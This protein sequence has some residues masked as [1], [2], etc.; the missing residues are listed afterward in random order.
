MS[1]P[2]ATG[3]GFAIA[4]GE[5]I[6]I[7]SLLYFRPGS[8][9]RMERRQLFATVEP[10]QPTERG[11]EVASA[12]LQALKDGFAA[13][14]DQPVPAALG[15]AFAD[16]NAAVREENRHRPSDGPDRRVFVGA[17]AVV[18][19]GRELVIAQV[20]PTQAA[21]VQEGQVYAFPALAS[22][23]PQFQPSFE[24][25]GPDTEPLGRSDQ[26]TVDIFRTIAA[27][28]D[29]IVM[30]ASAI[31]IAAARDLSSISSLTESAI[32]LLQDALRPGDPDRVVDHF[33]QVIERYRLDDAHAAC[34]TIGRLHSLDP[35][36]AREYAARAGL[37]WGL[38]RPVVNPTSPARAR[39][40]RSR[41]ATRRPA[42]RSAL[43][44][45]RP[46]PDLNRAVV[47]SVRRCA[48]LAARRRQR[49][50]PSSPLLDRHREL[51]GAPLHLPWHVSVPGER[52]LTWVP[53]HRP[54][55]RKDGTTVFAGG[56]IPGAIDLRPFSP[57]LPPVPAAEIHDHTE[58]AAKAASPASTG[59]AL[60]E[61]QPGWF[62]RARIAAMSFTE[63]IAPP[64]PARGH[65][66]ARRVAP[67]ALSIERHRA[68]F[69]IGIT[70]DFRS[71]LPR[72]SI[73]PV[74]RPILFVIL[75]IL[76]AFSTFGYI[77]ARILPD[78]EAA[79]IERLLS[80][81]NDHITGAEQAT[82]RTI[83]FRELAQASEALE[84]AQIEG[85]DPDEV[86]TV[87]ARL[88][89]ARDRA[90]GI[91]RLAAGNQIG[92]LPLAAS[93]HHII[94]TGDEIYIV[95]DALY[96]FDRG[97]HRLIRTLAPG[98]RLGETIVGDFQ[99]VG[100]DGGSLL[101]TDGSV[102]YTLNAL[103]DWG[104][105]ALSPE[106]G[107]ASV[108]A[109]ASIAGYDGNLYLLDQSEGRILRFSDE[110]EQ[111]QPL[112]WTN[113]VAQS[114]LQTARD[115]VVDGEIHVLTADGRILTFFQGLLDRTYGPPP[116]PDLVNSVS[117][118]TSADGSALYLVD[119]GDAATPGRIFRLDLT[120]GEF[121]EF[122]AAPVDGVSPFLGLQDAIVDEAT[123]TLVLITANSLWQLPIAV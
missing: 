95:S 58:S 122:I 108:W 59:Q 114:D 27:P 106:A 116:G 76:I 84:Q 60:D 111:A 117:L 14:A 22:W 69:D 88:D 109:A 45:D 31:P 99:F 53:I 96:R 61:R 4:N 30:C 6:D 97:G 121:Q 26:A 86:A 115:L 104:L 72:A 56:A 74:A 68:G 112:D 65:G 82:E 29:L 55:K 46:D 48:L 3:V 16:A 13:A 77:R 102:A 94:Q 100:S 64:R 10:L 34:F 33:D 66:R 119:G 5:P 63:R 98:D 20:P 103:G 32:A 78:R 87:R 57:P 12:A 15:R 44:H 110:D 101:L 93:G 9:R 28:G 81:A 89:A 91:I 25:L 73:G 50:R 11:R 75:A 118:S 85:V 67:G 90:Q 2:A 70:S 120:I 62:E 83:V 36:I 40:N 51:I 18:L 1:I 71:R 41:R 7:G 47:E 38:G 21:V 19:D 43:Q 123:D 54:A 92:G 107:Q 80:T 37:A 113:G 17:S 42:T 79:A 49:A 39:A 24:R 52:G 23:S 105:R 35:R 8:R